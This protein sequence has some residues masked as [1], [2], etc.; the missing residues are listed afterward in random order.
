L[1]LQITIDGKTYEVEVEVLEEDEGPEIP[2]YSPH[3]AASVATGSAHLPTHTSSWDS[4]GKKCRSPLMGV[5]IKV[6]VEAGRE[7]QAGEVLLVLEAMKMETNIAAPRAGIVKTIHAA[8]GDSI[9][10]NQILVELE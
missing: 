8:H 4:E 1:K 10:Q 9:K 6:N 5:V 7:V 2:K 3:R